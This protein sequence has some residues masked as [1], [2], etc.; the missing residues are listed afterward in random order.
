[1]THLIN[2]GKFTIREPL[3]SK[4]IRLVTLDTALDSYELRQSNI[5]ASCMAYSLARAGGVPFF[6][7]LIA[8]M[9]MTQRIEC[10]Y[11]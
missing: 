6:R 8:P 4:D 7:S 9:R 10:G 1:M 2:G 11:E 3:W 5:V